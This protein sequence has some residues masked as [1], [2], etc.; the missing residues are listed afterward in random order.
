MGHSNGYYFASNLKPIF[1]AQMSV[2]RVIADEWAVDIIPYS[3]FT[4]ETVLIGL[5]NILGSFQFLPGPLSLK[6][7]V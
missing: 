3:F 1:T 5:E 2:R 4:P 6:Q 7:A